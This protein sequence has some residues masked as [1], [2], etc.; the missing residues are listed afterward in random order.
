MSEAQRSRQAR[1]LAEAA[2]VR[3]VSAYGETP[4]FV[5]LGGLVPDLLCSDAARQHVGTTDVDVQVDL[6]IQA[7]AGNAARLERALRAGGFKPSGEYAW[8]WQDQSVLGAVVKIEFLADLPT[9]PAEA[10]VT[11]DGSEALG[12]VNLRGTGFAARDWQLR[13]LT[14]D[15]SGQPTTVEV[16]VT[17]LPAYL[18]AKTH[19]AYGRRFERDWYDIAYVVLH[20]DAGGPDAAVTRVRA[21]FAADLVGQTATALTELAA[22]FFDANAQGSLAYAMTMHRLHPDL[23]ADV[24]ATTPDPGDLCSG[25]RAVQPGLLDPHL[26]YLHQ[27][28]DEG[29]RSTERLHQEIRARGYRGSLRTLRRHTARLRQDTAPPARPPAPASKKVAAWI[30]TPPGNLTD[31]DRAALD[32]I[33]GRCPELAATRALVRDFAS[34]LTHRTGSKLPHW[35]SQAE[36]STVRQLH[37]FAAGL[38]KD[39]PAV[40]AGLTL[41]SSSGTVEGHVNR[42][43]MIKRQMYG[44]A[45]PDLLRKRVL[46]AD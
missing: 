3:I 42:I 30:L 23:D 39:W 14:A 5:L 19:A 27:R 43:K 25:T 22:N 28:W 46:L 40:T 36:A 18:L 34:M 41:P 38:R 7:G 32:A 35:A 31:D 1:A 20:N 37:S 13:T 6:E 26:P 17:T 2:L 29:C 11:F 16:R 10:T 4:E 12:A 21:V 33:T 45:K 24:L 8:R 9:V 15:V 44:R